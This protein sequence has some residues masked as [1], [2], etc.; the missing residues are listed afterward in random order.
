MQ[1][2]DVWHVVWILVLVVGVVLLGLTLVIALGYRESSTFA[3]FSSIW[4]LFVGLI[5]FIVTGQSQIPGSVRLRDSP[6]FSGFSRSPLAWPDRP[7][8]GQ[9]W[10]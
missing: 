9:L 4:G 8:W 2:L 5:G 1:K 6:S 7:S 3:N 10:H